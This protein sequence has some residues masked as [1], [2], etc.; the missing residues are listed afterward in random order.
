MAFLPTKMKA[1]ILCAGILLTGFETLA[2]K[3]ISIYT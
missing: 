2:D 1:G 3:H